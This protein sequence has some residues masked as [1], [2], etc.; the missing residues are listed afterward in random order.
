MFC[1]FKGFPF[2]VCIFVSAEPPALTIQP[3]RK[4]SADLDRNVDIPCQ[5]TGASVRGA[6]TGIEESGVICGK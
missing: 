4:I 1:S 6:W 3:K 2:C 5:A